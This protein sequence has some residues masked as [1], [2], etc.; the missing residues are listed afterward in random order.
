[1]KVLRGHDKTKLKVVRLFW[2][3]SIRSGSWIFDFGHWALART[4]KNQN[5][6][7]DTLDTF[8]GRCLKRDRSIDVCSLTVDQDGFGLFRILSIFLEL[9]ISESK[10]GRKVLESAEDPTFNTRNLQ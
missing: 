4:C 5:I 9:S 6:R 3:P 1:M 10:L 2:S 7:K 8:I